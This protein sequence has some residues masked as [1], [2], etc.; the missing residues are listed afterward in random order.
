MIQKN[1]IIVVIVLIIGAVGLFY[2][3]P[4]KSA[5]NQAIN[6]SQ[7]NN[8]NQT[9][10]QNNMAQDLKI[11]TLIGGSGPEAKSGDMVTVNYT[12]TL[13]D[14]TKFDSSLN[15]G[16]TPFEFT[17]D[18]SSVIQGW[19]M[20]VAGMKVGEKRKL[21]IPSGLAYGSDGRPP[22]IPQNATL[23]FEIDLLKIN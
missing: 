15:P 11:E 4:K 14:G 6:Q 20:G 9:Q 5:S 8:L 17:I 19:H 2:F 10:N 21:I 3:V 12:G 13:E 1:I 23:I 16:R 18:K 22:I 7:N